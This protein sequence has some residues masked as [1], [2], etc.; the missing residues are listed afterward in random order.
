MLYWAFL[1]NAVKWVYFHV[2]ILLLLY[3]KN[4][5]DIENYTSI[6]KVYCIGG[7][8]RRLR[9]LQAFTKIWRTL[10]NISMCSTS[11]CF[12]TF[13]PVVD[14]LA[15]QRF[16]RLDAQAHELGADCGAEGRKLLFLPSFGSCDACLDYFSIC[17]ASLLKLSMALLL[18]NGSLASTYC[19]HAPNATNSDWFH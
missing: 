15:W 10:P 7:A 9:T 1:R 12:T 14:L 2:F 17:N 8:N 3:P 18:I 13:Y 11:L 16:V 4:L 19:M 6:N 5:Y